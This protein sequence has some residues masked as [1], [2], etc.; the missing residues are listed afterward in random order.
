MGL[1][2]IGNTCFLNSIIQF[3]FA[4]EKFR[5]DLI[6]KYGGFK[7]ASNGKFGKLL[8][9]IFKSIK[10]NDKRPAALSDQK[11]ILN[12]MVSK[13]EEINNEYQRHFQEDAI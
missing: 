10:E 2:N 12:V 1:P 8:G 6:A 5:E 4:A 9:M 7:E 13:L 11:K 3:L